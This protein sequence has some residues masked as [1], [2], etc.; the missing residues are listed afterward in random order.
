MDDGQAMKFSNINGQV[1]KSDG[2]Q[3]PNP[4]SRVLNYQYRAALR[5]AKK[6]A[7]PE[8]DTAYPPVP[9]KSGSPGAWRADAVNRYF[10]SLAP[11]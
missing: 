2:R 4:Y 7:W 9:S 11:V 8:P 1:L 6:N 3:A 10:A 5:T